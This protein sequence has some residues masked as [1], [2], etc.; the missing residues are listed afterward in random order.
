MTDTMFG[1]DG[2]RIRYSRQGEGP[3]VVLIHGIPTHGFLWRNVAS[4]LQQAGRDVIVLDMLGYGASDKPLQV[5]LGIAAQASRISALLSSIGWAGGTFVG[6]DIGGG[7]TQLLAL[8]DR[9]RVKRLVLVDA[10]AYDSFPEPGIARLQD[11]V[12]D[13]ILGAPDF[14]LAKGLTKGFTRGLVRT[15]R[16][17][18]DLVAAYERPFHGVEGRRAYLRAARALRTEELASRMDEVERLD[19][20]TLIIWGGRDVFQPPSYGARLAAAMRHA[21]LEVIDD[22]GHFL[23]ED[24]PEKLADLIADFTA[25]SEK[26]DSNVSYNT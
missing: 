8:D 25:P 12:W 5:D 15:D 13:G 23:P 7:V 14:D 21:R 4:R 16:V 6:H 24:E 10:I 11:P 19:V 1:P 22:A 17:T 18:P 2:E 20:P 3:S 9:A 26:E